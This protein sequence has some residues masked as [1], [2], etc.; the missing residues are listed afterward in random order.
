MSIQ[1][2]FTT[3][4]FENNAAAILAI[5]KGEVASAA[6]NLTETVAKEED[7]VPAK[8]PAARKPAAKQ[9]GRA[10]V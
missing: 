5:L 10:H 9:I 6:A 8:K 1:V 3:E 2:T 7:P 4:Q